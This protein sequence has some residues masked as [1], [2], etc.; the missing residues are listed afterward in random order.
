[1]KKITLSA[2]EELIKRVQA[3]ARKEKTTLTKEFRQWLE[4]YAA[5]PAK[6]VKSATK[7]RR[8]PKESALTRCVNALKDFEQKLEEKL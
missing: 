2:D 8:K 3:K 7:S 1:M 6:V 4:D 5:E